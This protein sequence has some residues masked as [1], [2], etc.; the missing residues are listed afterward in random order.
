MPN[1]AEM[2]RL[3]L[4]MRSHP[5]GIIYR[6]SNFVPSFYPRAFVPSWQQNFYKKIKKK[7]RTHVRPL[8][9]KHA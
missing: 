3:L 7:G 1:S 4:M 6:I 8:V 5:L 9:R 2:Q